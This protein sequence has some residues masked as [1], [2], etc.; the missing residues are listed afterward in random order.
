V[1]VLKYNLRRQPTLIK[2]NRLGQS[3]DLP[4]PPV[5]LLCCQRSLVSH[6]GSRRTPDEPLAFRQ[7]QRVTRRTSRVPAGTTSLQTNLS[8]L[9]H[10]QRLSKLDNVRRLDVC[11]LDNVCRLFLD[12][13][14]TSTSVDSGFYDQTV[15]RFLNSSKLLCYYGVVSLTFN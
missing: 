11:R 1:K 6:T 15:K 7:V 9:Q 14:T 13:T 12:S 4:G 2:K 10:V 8:R 3:H 5:E